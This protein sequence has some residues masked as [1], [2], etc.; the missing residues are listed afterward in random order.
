MINAYKTSG[1]LVLL[2]CVHYNLHRL[3]AL[4]PS[5]GESPGLFPFL[6]V[7]VTNTERGGSSVVLEG[8]E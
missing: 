7:R 5:V 3:T 8:E 1:C 4:V 2:G 6:L